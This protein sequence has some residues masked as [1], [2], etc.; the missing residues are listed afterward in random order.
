MPKVSVIM[1]VYNG[2]LF[3][4]RAIDSL[5]SQ[6]FH[7]WELVVVD[8]GSTDSTP[9]ILE[10]FRDKRIRIIRQPNSG[11]ASARNVGLGHATG[12]YISFLDADDLYLPNAIEDLSFFLDLHPEYHIV[13]SDGQIC[14]HE[15]NPLMRLSE[16]RSGIYTGNVL[17]QLVISSSVITVPV[18][19]MVRMSKIQECSAQFDPEL[20]I[21][22]DWDFWIQ[23]AV[24]AQFGYLDKMTCKYRVHNT[25]ITRRVDVE[26]RQRDQALARMK[27]MNSTWFTTLSLSTRELFFA[28]LLMNLV[29]KDPHAQN[30]ILRSPQFSVLPAHVRS[31]LWRTVGINVLQY[32]R[33][34]DIANSYFS[35][36]QKI[37]P[38][39][40]KTKI[41]I[42]GLKWGPGITLQAVKL[43]KHSLRTI[44]QLTSVHHAQSRRLQ[45]LFGL[46]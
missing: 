27:V 42:W 18:C 9:Q 8:D 38:N 3:I 17:E 34:A 6:S 44:H 23:L 20:V 39:D 25:N 4:N 35:E 15:D 21:G 1:P 14:D 19:T 36:A 41:L 32:E 28:E 11:E 37:T 26:K 7:D 31:R 16:I 24:N 12:E 46:N 2:E 5:L 13:Y 40:R 29:Y 10:G 33:N 22:P 43:W 45:K 30:A